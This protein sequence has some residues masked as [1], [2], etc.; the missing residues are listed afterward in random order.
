[1][2]KILLIGAILLFST[3]LVSVAAA[4]KINLFLSPSPDTE[5]DAY[6]IFSISYNKDLSIGDFSCKG[7]HLKPNTEFIITNYE[8]PMA[9]DLGKGTTNANGN[10]NIHGTFNWGA[11][12]PFCSVMLVP[13]YDFEN[14]NDP[15]YIGDTEFWL[16]GSF[17]VP[18]PET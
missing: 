12:L 3:T 6:G 14:L 8:W 5:E 10:L 15:W 16:Y 2:K 1:M 9:L 18:Y 7:K 4:Q 13:S 17:D 11:P